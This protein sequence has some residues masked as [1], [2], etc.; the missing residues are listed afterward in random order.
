MRKEKASSTIRI[1]P[2]VRKKLK[3]IAVKKDIT[4]NDVIEIYLVG[5]KNYIRKII[6]N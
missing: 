2:S 6:S 1:K 4:I 3:L 5:N